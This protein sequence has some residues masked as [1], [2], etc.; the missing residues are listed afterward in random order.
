MIEVCLDEVCV[1]EVFV[2]E[3]CLVTGSD[4]VEVKHRTPVLVVH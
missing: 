1:G 4:S 2:G 3:L